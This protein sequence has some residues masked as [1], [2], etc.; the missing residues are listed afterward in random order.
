MYCSKI[1][2][3][4]E[5]GEDVAV[6]AFVKVHNGNYSIKNE[7]ELRQVIWPIAKNLCYDVKRNDIPFRRYVKQYNTEESYSE[8][9]VDYD[10]IETEIIEKAFRALKRLKAKDRKIVTLYLNGMWAGE[11][12]R[13]LNINL[14]AVHRV[15]EAFF[16]KMSKYKQLR[17]H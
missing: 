8:Y 11:I 6:D 16:K 5:D 3:S 17:I 9:D 14:R 2:D 7:K 4:T 15:K 12:S 13:T 10:R 1:L